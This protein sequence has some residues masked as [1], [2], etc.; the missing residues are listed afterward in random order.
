[1]KRTY[2]V[3]I[4]EWIIGKSFKVK[5]TDVNDDDNVITTKFRKNN[6][7]THAIYEQLENR[8]VDEIQLAVGHIN[9][10]ETGWLLQDTQLE[11][12]IILAVL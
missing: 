12:Q 4:T 2:S 9:I 11:G 6:E 10:G 7:H 8:I 1:M 3:T 5:L